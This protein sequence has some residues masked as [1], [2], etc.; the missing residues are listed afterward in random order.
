MSNEFNN[1]ERLEAVQDPTSDKETG[2]RLLD[3]VFFSELKRLKSFLAP[4]KEI[5]GVAEKD[6]PAPAKVGDKVIVMPTPGGIP[7]GAQPYTANV[8]GVVPP[9]L[10]EE[11]GRRNPYQ[12]SFVQTL[13]STREIQVNPLLPWIFGKKNYNGAR[14]VYDANGK[15]KLPGKKAR[16]EGDKASDDAEVNAA[17]EFT[18]HVR[19]FYKDLF[20][21]NSIDGKGMKFVSTVNYGENYENAFWNGS[22]MT[23]GRP[24]KDS[25]FK[26]FVL[27]DIC[28]HEITHGVT[29]KESSLKYYG[30]S[31]A[32]NESL[33]DIFGELV[34]QRSKN[35]KATE[36]DWIVGDG[37]WKDTVKG[38]GLR[39]MLH[40]GEAYNDPKIGKDPQPAHM[41]DYI[42]TTR[43]N[44]GVHYNSGIPNRAFALFATSVGGYAWEEPGHIWY[45]ARKNAGKEPS[46]AQFAYHT[47]EAAKKLGFTADVEKLQKAWESVGVTPSAEE[48]DLLT[49]KKPVLQPRSKKEQE[50]A[51]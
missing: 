27:L 37:I 43:D 33:S 5:N 15:E 44:G 31:G 45:E 19:N 25:P 8:Y 42:K 28:A 2:T 30:Q 11:L 13:Q 12:P 41:K 22:Q 14:E 20:G 46:F 49:P 1:G 16:F 51:A 17:Y 21:R 29:E 18:G 3:D 9:Y 40:P 7:D 24:G 6:E 10:L 34:Q 39:D 32:L 47:I 48:K 36:A 50:Q 23:Y 26:T 4:I 35:Q 38:K